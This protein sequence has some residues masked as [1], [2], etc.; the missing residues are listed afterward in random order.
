MMS[1]YDIDEIMKTIPHRYPFLLIDK[2][3]AMEEGVSVTAE[4]NVTMNEPFFQGHYPDN[5]IM[6]GVLIIEAMA[7]AASFMALKSIKSDKPLTPLFAGIDKA[8]FKKPVRPGDI[9]TIEV[10]VSKKKGSI[11]YADSTAKVDGKLACKA[12]I[13]A[14]FSA[15]E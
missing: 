10:T 6:P 7:Q 12:T 5:P 9:L 14:V 13:I 8:R 3:V 1:L 4:K 15:L 11:W 2:I